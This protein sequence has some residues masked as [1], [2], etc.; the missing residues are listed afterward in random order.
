M[1]TGRASRNRFRAG[2]VLSGAGMPVV[3]VVAVVAAVLAVGGLVLATNSD[4]RTHHVTVDGVPLDEVHPAASGRRPGVVVAHGFAGSAR[5]MAPFGDTLAARGY[6]VVLLDFAGHGASTRRLTGDAVLQRDLDVAVAHLRSLPDVDPARIALVGHSMGAGAVAEYGA[7]HPDVTATVAISLPDATGLPPDRPEHLLLLVGGLEFP[8]FRAAVDE[9]AKGRD[10]TAVTVPG[11]EH[12]SILYAPRTHREVVRW[13]DQNLGA[14]SGP[15]PTPLR[16]PA[17]AG[18]M[19]LG[20][21]IG[22]YPPARLVLGDSGARWPRFRLDL[23]PRVLAVSAVAALLGLVVAAVLPNGRFPL[24]TAGFVV[25]F[26]LVLGGA[27]I[28]YQVWRGPKWSEPASYRAVVA[29][30]LFVAY[31][32]AAVAVPLQ[33]GVAHAVPV[34][35]RWW[36]LLVVWAGFAALAYGAERFAGPNALA[37]SAVATI[38]L[39]L[40]AG[41]GLANGFLVLVVPLIAVLLFWQAVWSAILR[42]FSAPTWAIAPVGALVV[43]WPLATALP[44]TG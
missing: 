36:L 19:L 1:T 7:S 34:G 10:R 9:A 28:A 41:L 25:A 30:P 40:A 39:T 8:Q 15:L 43:A 18:L 32:G 12:I 20:F 14:T 17:G 4:L 24:A 21:L 31:A 27:L 23:L 22:L 33:V 3:A 5:L 2:G 16:R 13:L 37:V 11:V 26:T 42:R 6:V 29:L 44:I 38:A 35:I